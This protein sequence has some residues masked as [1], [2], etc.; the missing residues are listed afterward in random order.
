MAAETSLALVTRQQ[1]AKVFKRDTRTIARWL[2][3][4]MPCAVK[5][6][7]GK[8]SM[9]SIPDCVEWLVQREIRAHTSEDGP[10][11]SPAIEQARLNQKRTEELELKLKVRRGELVEK[12]AIIDEYVDL[13]VA[14]KSRIRAVPDAIADQLVGLS[15]GAIKHLLLALLDEALQELARGMDV[16]PDVPADE[17]DETL[18][19]AGA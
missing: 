19:E 18:V 9:Y 3:D 14:V 16:L 8:P 15:P 11:L 13:A 7:G 6:R 2:E 5:G 17:D 12:A 10:V 1:L 4:A